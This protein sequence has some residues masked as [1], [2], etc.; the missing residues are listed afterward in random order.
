MI[1]LPEEKND[2][3]NFASRWS[4]RKLAEKEREDTESIPVI[5]E[6][7]AGEV[8]ETEIK[9]ED[10]PDIEGLEKDSDYTPFMQDGVPEKLKRLALRKLWMSDPAFGFLDGLNDYDEDYSAIGIIAQEVTTNY[11][12][13]RGMVDPNDP[14]E[15]LED[16]TEEETAE[17]V[18][19]VSDADETQETEEGD[20]ETEEDQA[21]EDQ[22]EEADDVGEDEIAEIDEGEPLDLDE[23]QPAEKPIRK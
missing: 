1:D 10:L 18:E 12:P 4:R 20:A 7:S 8:T 15:N 11:V 16:E 17:E 22:P 6:A 21:S 2:G 5:E 19:E 23:L 9:E 14:E 13:G 3:E